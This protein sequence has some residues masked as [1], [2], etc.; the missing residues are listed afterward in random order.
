LS[1]STVIEFVRITVLVA[2]EGPSD[3]GG[4][5]AAGAGLAAS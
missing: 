5:G 2:V 4:F 3:E 1:S